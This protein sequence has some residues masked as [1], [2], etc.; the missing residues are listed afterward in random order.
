L[1]NQG[2]IRKKYKKLQIQKEEEKLQKN[3]SEKKLKTEKTRTP[4]PNK[5][6]TKK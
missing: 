3:K 5:E 2:K 6:K 1:R 4:A